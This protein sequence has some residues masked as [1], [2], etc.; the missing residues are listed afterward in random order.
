MRFFKD[1]LATLTTQGGTLL[2]GMVFSVLV[3]RLLGPD[4]R[5]IL[6]L[7]F[8]IPA[9]GTTHADYFFGPIP[10]SRAMKPEE[11]K[12]D[13]ETNTG[14]V[15]VERLA[16]IDPLQCPATLVFGHGPFTWGQEPAQAVETA[17]TVEHLARLASETIRIDPY[18][19]PLG[20]DLLEKHYLR[21]HGPGRYYGQD[22]AER[23]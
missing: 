14:R 2:L 12:T 17:I 8:L 18:P 4:G 3:A 20:K 21:K 7:V 6:T 19:P 15:I 9:M 16:G 1:T 11:V 13:Y 5:A 10:C 23:E 22:R